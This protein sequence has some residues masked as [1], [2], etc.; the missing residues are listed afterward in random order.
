[1][2]SGNKKHIMIGRVPMW[3][4]HDV[5]LLIVNTGI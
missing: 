3:F 4:Y 5:N 2:N 1:M